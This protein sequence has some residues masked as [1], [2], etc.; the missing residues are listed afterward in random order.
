MRL[1]EEIFGEEEAQTARCTLYVG[2][3]GYFQGVKS[4]GDF[5]SEKI[6]LYFPRASVE[7]EGV[8]LSIG[9]YCE[10]DLRLLGKVQSI[11]LLG[12]DGASI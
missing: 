11:R 7:I 12:K 8:D 9:K 2:G 5:C 10:G 3:G 1:F 4:V 6:V